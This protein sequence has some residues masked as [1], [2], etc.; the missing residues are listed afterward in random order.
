M[1]FDFGGNNSGGSFSWRE[2]GKNER[3]LSWLDVSI[4]GWE[5]ESVYFQK[6]NWADPMNKT[7]IV[8]QMISG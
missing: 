3:H 6:N 8:S 5:S 1:N 7:K 2:I 4:L